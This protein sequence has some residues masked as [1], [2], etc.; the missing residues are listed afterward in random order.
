MTFTKTMKLKSLVTMLA[1]GAALS[2]LA[3]AESGA[4]A[5]AS[6]TEAAAVEGNETIKV[7]VVN[8]SGGG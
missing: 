6:K 8:S 3:I 2:G 4:D 1:T 5:P 7:Y